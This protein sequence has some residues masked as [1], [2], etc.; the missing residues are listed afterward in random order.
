M[1]HLFV[2]TDDYIPGGAGGL[3]DGDTTAYNSPIRPVVFA[4]DV[5]E[6]PTDIEQSALTTSASKLAELLWRYLK[7]QGAWICRLPEHGKL[8]G[9]VGRMESASREI[10]APLCDI[11]SEFL[12]LTPIGWNAYSPHEVLPVV[13]HPEYGVFRVRDGDFQ[14][15]PSRSKVYR[16]IPTHHVCRGEIV[17]GVNGSLKVIESADPYRFELNGITALVV[18]NGK[19][20]PARLVLGLT[21]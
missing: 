5:P 9:N 8:V 21:I 6:L 13:R 20:R 16:E 17:Q 14:R 15:L 18:E 2:D 1:P 3:D 12:A 19:Y 10:F 4:E 11:T 7:G